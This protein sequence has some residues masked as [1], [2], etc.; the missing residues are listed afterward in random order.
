MF[1]SLVPSMGRTREQQNSHKGGTR[2]KHNS[3]KRQNI[4]TESWPVITRRTPCSDD[5][6]LKL[7]HIQNLTLSKRGRSLGAEYGTD[8]RREVVVDKETWTFGKPRSLF[9]FSIGLH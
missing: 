6:T 5:Q 3:Y 1:P 8:R 4:E 7:H 2:E 9:Q